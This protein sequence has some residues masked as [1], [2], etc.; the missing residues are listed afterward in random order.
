ML[1]ILIRATAKDTV[2]SSNTIAIRCCKQISGTGEVI[3]GGGLGDATRT[4][5]SP[6]PNPAV[7]ERSR[8]KP[9]LWGH[10][11]DHRKWE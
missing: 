7:T 6:T 5:T 1:R 8:A 9:R 2:A 10:L 11:C 3:D 4:R